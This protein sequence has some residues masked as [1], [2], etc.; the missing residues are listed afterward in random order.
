MK[1]LL[2]AIDHHCSD[3]CIYITKN[4][5]VIENIESVIWNYRSCIHF[6]PMLD[7]NFVEYNKNHIDVVSEKPKTEEIEKILQLCDTYA[8]EH[9]K[10]IHMHTG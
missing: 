1:I 5:G 9:I 6:K 4:C 3:I 8:S 7:F 2:E 10:K